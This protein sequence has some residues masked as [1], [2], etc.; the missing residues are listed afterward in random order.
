M[1]TVHRRHNFTQTPSRPKLLPSVTVNECKASLSTDGAGWAWSTGASPPGRLCYA[2]ALEC[3]SAFLA[4]PQLGQRRAQRPT[5]VADGNVLTHTAWRTAPFACHFVALQ[6]KL[7]SEGL[8]ADAVCHPCGP[9][10]SSP[11][12]GVSVLGGC[13]CIGSRGSWHT[14]GVGHTRMGRCTATLDG[15]V[16]SD[17]GGADGRSSIQSGCFTQRW[18]NKIVPTMCGPRWICSR[19]GAVWKVL[20]SVQRR[21]GRRCASVHLAARVALCVPTMALIPLTL[22][23][24]SEHGHA[25]V[26]VTPHWP[27]MHWQAEIY[28]LLRAQL[29]SPPPR[30]DQS[31]ICTQSTCCCGLGPWMDEFIFVR[32][33]AACDCH[34]PKR[35][36]VSP[37]LGLD[38]TVSWRVPFQ[39]LVGVIFFFPAGPNW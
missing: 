3:L 19:L 12:E 28:Q 35:S 13:T 4:T 29:W 17:A 32:A 37:P 39:C 6:F 14:E 27:A 36:C 7:G 30:R 11:H 38:M 22:P 34:R 31:F 33:H 2:C 20:F 26:M 16:F 21:R 5:K 1:N 25:L 18:W 10:G 9:P 15:P 23:R 24:V 8:R